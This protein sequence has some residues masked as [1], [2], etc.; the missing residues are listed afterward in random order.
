ME[1]E[2]ID[3]YL[4]AGRI[5]KMALEHAK[6]LAEPGTLL[7]DIAEDVEKLIR[8]NN[9]K[10]AFPLNLS[11]NNE[12]A[13]YT[14]FTGDKKKLKT[15][16]LLKIDIGAHIDGYMSDNAATVEVGEGGNY[17]DLIESTRSALN[18]AISVVR[19]MQRIGEIGRVIGSTI[20]SYGFKPVKNLGGHGINRY[21]LHSSIFIPNY[22]DGNA[23]QLSPGIAIAIE[24]FASTGIGMIHNGPGGNIY[25]LSGTKVRKDELIYQNFNTAPF[26]ERWVNDVIPNPEKYMK[27]MMKIRELSEF[28]VLKEHVN[29][30]I[31]QSEHT[32]LVLPDRVI[33]T[34]K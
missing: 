26:A 28:P 7:L 9:A 4:E 23:R 32:L 24:P 27:K 18:K 8:D 11:I 6:T 16:D 33:V 3:K 25:I 2:V 29:A 17:T 5:G 34:T 14:P 13:H 19:P 20:E 22:N 15:G 1:K 21:D 30:R 31:A 10:P 12:A